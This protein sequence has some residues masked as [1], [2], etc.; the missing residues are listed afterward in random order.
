MATYNFSDF[1]PDE[2]PYGQDDTMPGQGEQTQGPNDT[3]S[4]APDINN[5]QQGMFESE[6][7]DTVA[8]P[9]SDDPISPAPGDGNEG[10]PVTQNEAPAETRK[11]QGDGEETADNEEADQ[12][13]KDDPSDVDDT[14]EQDD[15]AEQDDTEEQDDADEE[16]DTEEEDSGPTDEE[17]ALGTT[18]EFDLETTEELIDPNRDEGDSLTPD[19]IEATKE[20]EADPDGDYLDADIKMPNVRDILEGVFLEND[21]EDENL[22]VGDYAE[23][24]EFDLETD[25]SLLSKFFQVID[26]T[27]IDTEDDLLSA[28]TEFTIDDEDFLDN[29]VALDGIDTFLDY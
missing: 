10:E 13:N 8:I 15:S 18:E 14:D 25:D 29:I 24:D 26:D 7:E 12:T 6:Q 27:N 5:T 1:H 19:D 2:G 4:E 28:F 11:A 3:A 22:P 17:V 21:L 9:G 20:V 23:R 16:D